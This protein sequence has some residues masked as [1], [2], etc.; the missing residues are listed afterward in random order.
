MRSLTACATLVAG[1]TAG[2]CGSDAHRPPPCGFATIVGA[3]VVIQE[4][5]KNVTKV[6]TDVPLGLPPR[7]PVRLVGGD[8]TVSLVGYD[9]DSGIVVG[10][11]GTGFPLQGGWALLIADDS[12]GV[13]HGALI[14]QS[15][16]P[17]PE[18]NYPTLGLVS[19]A[20]RTIP[21]Y[22]VRVHWRDVSNPRCPLLGA[23][24][25]E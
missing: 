19:G 6:I 15:A 24:P 12:T 1:L 9:G 17:G 11:E 2:A 21:L 20:T 25:A 18:L 22:G 3:P 14:Y 8:Q 7:L 4:T 16:G 23:A 13:F 5:F 10:F